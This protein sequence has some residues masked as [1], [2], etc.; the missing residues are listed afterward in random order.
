MMPNTDLP[1][2]R[3]SDK[4]TRL[5]TPDPWEVI[6]RAAEDRTAAVAAFWRAAFRGATAFAAARFGPRGNTTPERS[7]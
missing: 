6:P 3:S 4:R 5:A 2:L 1:P 7:R